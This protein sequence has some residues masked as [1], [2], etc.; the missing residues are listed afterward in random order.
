M[1]RTSLRGKGGIV[2]RIPLLHRPRV[3]G[4][5]HTL[6]AAKY[7]TEQGQRVCSEIHNILVGKPL[8][9]SSGMPARFPCMSEHRRPPGRI[10]AGNPNDVQIVVL[11]AITADETNEVYCS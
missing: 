8:E 1:E 4:R 5:L 11:V 2:A 9:T 7:P 10:A 3:V 6:K